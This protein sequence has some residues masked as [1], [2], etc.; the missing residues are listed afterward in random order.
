MKRY[1]CICRVNNRH[2]AKQNNP[3]NEWEP[4]L[5]NIDQII[6]INY[7]AEEF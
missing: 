6:E 2:S 3:K 7:M 5:Q 1:I 4:N